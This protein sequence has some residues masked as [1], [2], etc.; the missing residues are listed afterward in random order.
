MMMT[1]MRSVR[2]LVACLA[3]LALLAGAGCSGSDS[4]SKKKR[5]PPASLEVSPPTVLL[6]E[7]GATVNLA[8]TGYV[9]G[10]PVDLTPSTEGT[11]YA[12]SDAAVA[13]VDAEGLVTRVG[14]GSA[15]LSIR[16]DAIT[17][18]IPLYSD[19]AAPLT[20]GD[21]DFVL[22]ET[23]IDVGQMVTVP[24]ILET[25]AREFGS[26]QVRITY[27]PDHFAFVKVAPGDDLGAPRAV[28]SDTPGE[29]EVV[30]AY[31]P[32]R[33]QALSGTFEVLR[34]QLRSKGASGDASKIT[35]TVVDIFD[36]AFPAVAI[37]PPTPRTFV[38]GDRWLAVR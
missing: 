15:V 10:K 13:D 38:S 36:G 19:E 11:T 37:G 35:G 27:D 33:G 32:A 24:M 30:H 14:P 20:E 34:I 1:A 18:Q 4:K 2:A 21:F 7:V 23:T 12:S 25:G 3:V 17:I 9:D 16:N 8:V 6:R 5:K 22:D 26:F 28:R 31:D 29:I